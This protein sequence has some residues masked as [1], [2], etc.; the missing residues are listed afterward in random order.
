MILV[1]HMPPFCTES[2]NFPDHYTLTNYYHMYFT[3]YHLDMSLCQAITCY[4]TKLTCHQSMCHYHVT[5]Y[6][7]TITVC[8]FPYHFLDMSLCHVSS[9]MCHLLTCHHATSSLIMDSA[10]KILGY[11]R[12][13]YRACLS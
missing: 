8:Q 4:F 6:H 13:Y 3:R 10:I 7:I 1:Q 12:P 11:H 2:P 9:T 5:I